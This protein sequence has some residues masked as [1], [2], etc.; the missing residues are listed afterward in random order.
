[1]RVSDIVEAGLCV[2]V[3]VCVVLISTQRFAPHLLRQLFTIEEKKKVSLLSHTTLFNVNENTTKKKNFP[4]FKTT[5]YSIKIKKKP[6]K[7]KKKSKKK[8]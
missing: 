6:K 4:F 1:M 2:C 3:C 8:K 7:K 5:K